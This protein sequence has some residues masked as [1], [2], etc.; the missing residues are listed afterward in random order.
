MQEFFTMTV[1]GEKT[2]TRDMTRILIST[3]D[4]KTE[5]QTEQ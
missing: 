4:G 2:S 1:F 3:S 5:F